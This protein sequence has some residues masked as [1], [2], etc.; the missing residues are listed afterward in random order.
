MEIIHMG[1]DN[2][3]E[4]YFIKDHIRNQIRKAIF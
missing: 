3:V 4:S 1:V 2:L